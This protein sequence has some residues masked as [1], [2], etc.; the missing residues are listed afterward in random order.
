[1]RM[2][3]LVMRVRELRV[4]GGEMRM[5]VRVVMWMIGRVRLVGRERLVRVVVR[6]GAGERR[7]RVRA[8]GEQRVH[9]AGRVR[10]VI[11]RSVLTV[12][13]D[14]RG[15]LLLEEEVVIDHRRLLRHA[16]LRGQRGRRRQRAGR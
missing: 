15:C 10:E 9:G 11:A 14:D 1:M 7:R 2:V 6:R 16:R 12:V 8:V 4:V 5:G 13:V 3:D